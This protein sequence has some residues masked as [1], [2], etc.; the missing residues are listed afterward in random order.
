MRIIWTGLCVT[1]QPA[2]ERR[3]RKKKQTG[4]SAL[5]RERGSA[6]PNDRPNKRNFL[7]CFVITS[8]FIPFRTGLCVTRLSDFLVLLCSFYYIILYIFT[9]LM[10]A[11]LILLILFFFCIC[12]YELNLNGIKLL[13]FL[14]IFCSQW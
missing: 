9:F 10:N 11:I 4:T 14:G 12:G 2:L 6:G 8:R 13:E 7:F 3:S 1:N 5:A